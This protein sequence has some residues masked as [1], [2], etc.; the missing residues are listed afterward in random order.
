[1]LSMR[2]QVSGQKYGGAK[3]KL[4]RCEQVLCP[5]QE[6][7][8]PQCVSVLSP[9]SFGIYIHSFVALLLSPV[10][11]RR[12]PF[13][14]NDIPSVRSI[15]PLPHQPVDWPS[16]LQPYVKKPLW[17]SL[18]A[19]A[20]HVSSCLHARSGH[21]SANRSPPHTLSPTSRRPSRLFSRSGC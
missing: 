8:D 19:P 11:C 1:M 13:E 21:V 16:V 14:L 3:W 7:E 5:Q 20:L 15:L 18:A 17:S 9:S 4:T 12:S 10:A 6:T 2:C